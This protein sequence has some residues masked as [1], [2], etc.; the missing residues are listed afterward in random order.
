[1]VMISD[2]LEK[3]RN[4]AAIVS[5]LDHDNIIKVYDMAERYRTVFII[6][7]Y[8]EGESILDKLVRLGKIPPNTAVNYLIQACQ[9][10]DY[11]YS[12][13][14]L[15]KDI[16]PGNLMVL[17]SGKV[18]LLDFGLA[19]SIHEDDGL[20]DGALPYLAP[21]LLEGEAA[22]LKSEIYALGISA[23]EMV[24]GHRPYPEDDP[25]VFARMRRSREI[26]DPADA[27]PEIPP[28]LRRFI[29]KSCRIDPMQRY[30]A[31]EDAIK[32]LTGT[33]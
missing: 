19:C 26:P 28:S 18:K 5:R 30:T 4:E 8:L 23:F 3:L 12:K 24:A 29:L 14:I 15:H 25:S 1:M 31:M 10:I 33:R 17:D 27:V 2:F 32:E 9:A 11:A 21:E 6:I 16:N 20:F 7:E 13:G 22:S